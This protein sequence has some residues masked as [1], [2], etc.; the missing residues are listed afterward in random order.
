[1]C[2]FPISAVA[3]S[4]PSLTSSP[5]PSPHHSSLPS[6]EP[7]AIFCDPRALSVPT[8]APIEFA[9]L[10]TL[11]PGDDEAHQLLLSGQVPKTPFQFPA[12]HRHAKSQS[13]TFEPILDFDEDDSTLSSFSPN[14]NVSFVG[15]K[16]QRL[17][18]LSFSED[19]ST[20]SELSSEYDEITAPGLITPADSEV[21]QISSPC[22]SHSHS[23]EES[24]SDYASVKDESKEDASGSQSN[25]GSDGS[26]STREQA[27]RRGRKQS[28]TDDPSKTFACT[29]CSR[30]FRRQE[31]LK[32]HYRSLHTGEKPFECQ[33]CGKKFSRSDNLAQHQR[34]HGTGSVVM[35]VLEAPQ[36]IAT[37]DHRALGHVL[38][39]A[40]AVATAEFPSSASSAS[41]MSDRDLSDGRAKKRKRAD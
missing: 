17:D 15:A 12:F 2:D 13:V 21:F 29:L 30:K 11:C 41:S 3:S 33:D 31:H 6:V 36:M 26:H 1:V 7:E 18:L 5:S 19:D 25:S 27:P 32:R 35:G 4:C 16:R 14:N 39:N 40:A 10:P 34:T 9:Q 22:E 28:L 20:F 37:F 24:D 23:E 38:Y 8:T